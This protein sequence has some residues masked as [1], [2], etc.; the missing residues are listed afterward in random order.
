VVQPGRSSSTGSVA[1]G[2]EVVPILGL[3][4]DEEYGLGLKLT[5]IPSKIKGEVQRKAQ[6]TL[7]DLF[8]A[9]LKQKLGL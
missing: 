4:D 2:S 9:R 5:D 8:I 6:K 7:W 1:S 3:G